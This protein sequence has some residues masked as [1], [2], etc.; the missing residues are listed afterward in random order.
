LSTQ[1]TLGAFGAEVPP[2]P[3]KPPPPELPIPPT[4]P[5]GFKFDCETCWLFRG[6]QFQTI[7][8]QE[9]RSSKCS[10]RTRIYE[11]QCRGR[12]W[13]DKDIEKRY[14]IPKPLISGAEV[15]KWR[16]RD[17]RRKNETP[18]IPDDDLEEQE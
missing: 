15:K 8:S 2:K 14:W 4:Y 5:P 12:H 10:F 13:L 9:I 17:E 16:L 11:K 7:N 18:G 6:Y 3:D 1:K